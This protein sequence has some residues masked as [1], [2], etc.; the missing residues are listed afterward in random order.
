MTF[1]HR[2]N[3]C[4]SDQQ[5]RNLSII[6]GPLHKIHNPVHPTRFVTEDAVKIIKLA[7]THKAIGPKFVVREIINRMNTRIDDGVTVGHLAHDR[8]PFWPLQ[9]HGHRNNFL[10]SHGKLTFQLASI[11]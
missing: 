3:I 8:R 10:G 1:T 6:I 9:V 7:H 11:Q 4:H 2:L 5:S